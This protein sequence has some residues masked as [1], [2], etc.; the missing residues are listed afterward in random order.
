MCFSAQCWTAYRLYQRE[1]GAGISIREFAEIYGYRRIKRTA[2]YIPR[3]V[4]AN[5]ADPQTDDE[6]AIKAM[7]DEFPALEERRLTQELFKQKQRL[8]AAQR[9]IAIKGTK[10]AAE[11]IRIA[12]SKIQQNE[13]WIANLRAKGPQPDDLRIY[14]KW[15]APVMILENGELVV[16]LMRYGCRLPGWS[17]QVDNAYD[18]YNARRNFLSTKGWKN[19]FGYKHAVMVA[20]R[21]YENVDRQVTEHDENG[22]PVQKTISVKLEFNPSNHQ[23]MLVACLY[24]HSKGWGDE[25]DFYSFAAITDDPPAEVAAAGHDR[26]IIPIKR[27][28][29]KA[30]LNPDPPKIDELHA[31]LEDRDRPYYEHRL[32]A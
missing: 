26:C 3:G 16:K 21:F 20:Q 15:W 8:I 14:P 30:W 27:E 32:T 19:L 29:L 6:R 10:K 18:T 12:S 5:F 24:N 13:Q 1:F 17:P 31:I 7:I 22:D 11:D 2:A 25:P 9:A 23:N 28:N 4:D